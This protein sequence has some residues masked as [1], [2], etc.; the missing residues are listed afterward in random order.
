MKA[1]FAGLLSIA[2]L[3]GCSKEPGEGGRALITGTV[4]RQD[5]NNNTGQPTGD[6]YPAQEE[7]VYIVYGDNTF[8]DDDLD[9]DPDGKFEFRWLRKGSYTIF[10][11]SECPTCD[12]G[13]EVKRVTVEVNDRKDVV[14][15][16]TI[17]IAN[18]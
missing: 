16:P 1:A 5:I 8:Y 13:T 2:L 3:A 11:Y 17:T 14:Q 10:V 12:A 4:L 7:K 18:W 15:V 6:P 9:T